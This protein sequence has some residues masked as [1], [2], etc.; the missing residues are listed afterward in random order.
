MWDYS[1]PIRNWNGDDID[2]GKIKETDY[3]LPIRNW[4]LFSLPLSKPVFLAIIVY[5]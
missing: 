3:S 4:N 1:L 2:Y 5:L